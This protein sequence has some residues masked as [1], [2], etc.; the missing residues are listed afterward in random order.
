MAGEGEEG[1]DSEVAILAF[2]EEG[3]IETQTPHPEC[4]ITQD[5]DASKTRT[6]PKELCEEREKV[7]FLHE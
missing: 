1:G 5:R 6:L 3:E 4:Q 2:L 7:S